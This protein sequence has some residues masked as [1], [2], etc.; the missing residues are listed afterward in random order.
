MEEKNPQ[1]W[2]GLKLPP[3]RYPPLWIPG[4]FPKPSSLK[5]FGGRGATKPEPPKS[6]AS[7]PRSPHFLQRVSCGVYVTV[8]PLACKQK[9]QPKRRGAPGAARWP[10]RYASPGRGF[11]RWGLSSRCPPPLV[12]R[13]SCGSRAAR[14]GFAGTQPCCSPSC[15]S[16][17]PAAQCLRVPAPAPSPQQ[18][19]RGAGT[20]RSR[21]AWRWREGEAGCSTAGL[22]AGEELRL[23]FVSKSK[24]CPLLSRP[25]QRAR[26]SGSPTHRA[27]A[28]CSASLGKEPG[29]LSRPWANSQESS[30]HR[31]RPEARWVPAW[32]QRPRTLPPPPPSWLK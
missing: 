31:G 8:C 3:D 7:T 11:R 12:A 4:S 22:S 28:E 6:K 23:P 16:P 2:L 18:A 1:L 21:R 32:P 5:A 24:H 29:V 15:T 9:A 19:T 10:Q 30:A 14:R 27:L 13:G 25:R 20:Q 17:P 26:H